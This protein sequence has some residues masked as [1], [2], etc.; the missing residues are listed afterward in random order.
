MR[1]IYHLLNTKCMEKEGS[2]LFLTEDVNKS[3]NVLLH[4]L[5]NIPISYVKEKSFKF[6]NGSK[7]FVK[8]EN[9]EAIRGV[10]FIGAIYFSD[11]LKV[12]NYLIPLLKSNK[13]WIYDGKSHIYWDYSR[14]N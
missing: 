11:D 10:N 6:S 8:N 9:L 7:L 13:G 14:S 2:Y 4:K 1:D 12:R 3:F 5:K